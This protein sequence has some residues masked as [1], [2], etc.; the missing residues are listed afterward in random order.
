[1][2]ALWD[3]S[4]VPYSYL[5]ICMVYI[6]VETFS[7]SVDLEDQETED[8]KQYQRCHYNAGNLVY[9]SEEAR[10]AYDGYRSPYG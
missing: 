4:N 3:S 1:M 2:V 5:R 10:E 9:E 6:V 7:L 8:S